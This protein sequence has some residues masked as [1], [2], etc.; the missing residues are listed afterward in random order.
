MVVLRRRDLHEKM[1]F[2]LKEINIFCAIRDIFL[3]IRVD[4]CYVV[5]YYANNIFTRL[6][7]KIENNSTWEGAFDQS[8]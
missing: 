8:E 1:I 5:D 7:N 6:K 2:R 4:F 3:L